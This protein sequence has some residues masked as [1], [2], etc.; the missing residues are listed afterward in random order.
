MAAKQE[1]ALIYRIAR[2]Y[3]LENLSQNEI[4]QIE[5]ISR[6]KVSRLLERARANGW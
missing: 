3:Y 1:D 4:A 5:Q 2:Y 6:S